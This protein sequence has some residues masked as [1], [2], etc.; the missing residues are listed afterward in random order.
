MTDGSMVEAIN[1]LTEADLFTIEE[2]A[3]LAPFL[4]QRDVARLV[5]EVRRL[6]AEND[7]LR[8]QAQPAGA[9]VA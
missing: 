4:V 5:R 7:R 2:R 3:H 1:Y 6:G 8:A 9:E